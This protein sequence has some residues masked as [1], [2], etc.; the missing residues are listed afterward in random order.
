MKETYLNPDMEICEFSVEDVVTTSSGSGLDESIPD[1]VWMPR[2][3]EGAP[4]YSA[5]N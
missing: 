5:W 4:D 2:V 3:N 1:N